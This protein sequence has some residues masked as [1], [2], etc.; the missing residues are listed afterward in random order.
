MKT[1]LYA[2]GFAALATIVSVG[3]TALA[4]TRLTQTAMIAVPAGFDGATGKKEKPLTQKTVLYYKGSKMRVESHDDV[5]IYDA[6][7]D[8]TLVLNAKTKTYYETSAADTV[9]A[10]SANPIFTLANASGEATVLNTQET[11]TIAGKTAQHFTYTITVRF[12]PKDANAPAALLAMLPTITISGDQWTIDSPD[13]SAAAKNRTASLLAKLPTGTGNGLKGIGEK[14]A[15]I[16]GIPVEQTQRFKIAAEG[17]VDTSSTEPRELVTTTQIKT[18]S[19]SEA[20]LPDSLFVVPSDYVR[21]APPKAP[22][23][24]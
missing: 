11:K 9:A 15:T 14:M 16:T 12:T 19:L 5:S 8:K 2:A 24:F 17:M 23:P 18:A 1:T 10:S 22:A 3:S 13:A 4:D 7:T 6:T 20:P 21:V